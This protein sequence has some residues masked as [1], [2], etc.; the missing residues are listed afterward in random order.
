MQP[1]YEKVLFR[2]SPR[3]HA[4][5]KLTRVVIRDFRDGPS[6]G[7]GRVAMSLETSAEP[8]SFSYQHSFLPRRQPWSKFESKLLNRTAVAARL[9][10]AMVRRLFK[11]AGFLL[12][13]S[14]LSSK[15]VDELDMI[16]ATS[17][18]IPAASARGSRMRFVVSLSLMLLDQCWT[19]AS[20]SW[21][22]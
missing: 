6:S 14:A 4:S 13:K 2:A 12:R 16:G 5:V 15:N 18:L 9:A 1:G 7:V 20:S 17:L 19:K 10:L 3:T 8:I 21:A 11:T 22:S